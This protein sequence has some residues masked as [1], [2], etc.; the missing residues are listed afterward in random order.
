MSSDQYVCN[1]KGILSYNQGQE[2]PNDIYSGGTLFVDHG[3]GSIRNYNQVGLGAMDTIH[4][5]E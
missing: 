5:K 2:G 4:C 1:I 3:S